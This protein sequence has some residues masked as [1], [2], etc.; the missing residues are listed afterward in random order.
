MGVKIESQFNELQAAEARYHSIFENAVEGILQAT[1]DGRILHANPSLA[2][3]CGYGSPKEF[4]QTISAL[5]QQLCR[6]PA[7]WTELLQKLEDTGIVS[8]FELHLLKK[9]GKPYGSPLMPAL[10]ER[11]QENLLRGKG[12]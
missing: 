1:T 4:M 9:D 11:P 7:Q 10:S 3:I 8:N 5:D 6:E 12:F 2:A